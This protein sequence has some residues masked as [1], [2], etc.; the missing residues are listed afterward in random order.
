MGRRIPVD[1][2]LNIKNWRYLLVDFWDEQWLDLLEFRHSTGV[3]LLLSQMTFIF[4]LGMNSNMDPFKDKPI[5]LH[6]SPYM[7]RDKPDS[8]VRPTIVDL[9]WPKSQSVNAGVARDE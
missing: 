2:K 7:T 1:A 3:H 6:V 8:N 4:I 5:D 9:S